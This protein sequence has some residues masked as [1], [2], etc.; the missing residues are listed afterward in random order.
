[1]TNN[2]EVTTN[3]HKSSIAQGSMIPLPALYQPQSFTPSLEEQKDDW[4]PS[5]ILGFLKRRALVIAGVA[6]LVMAGV[7][8]KT[9]TEKPIYQSDFLMLVEPLKDE[10]QWKNITSP[11][12]DDNLPKS[13]LD[14]ES[15]I[16][17]LK[18]RELLDKA[19]NNLKPIYPNISFN[20]LA[21]N[22][23][24]NR[25]RKTKALN[26][27]YSSPDAKKVK[28][29]LDA[30]AQSY[31][32]Y[33]LQERQTELRQGLQFVEEKLPPLRNRVDKLENQIKTFRQKYNFYNPESELGLITGQLSS[34]I[35]KRQSIDTELATLR[36]NLASLQANPG[37]LAVLN[38]AKLYQNLLSQVRQLEA[39]IAQESARF[40][41][42]NPR[43]QTFLDRRQRLL[44]LL[45]QE[46][47]RILGVQLAGVVT[48]IQLLEVRSQELAKIERQ[49]QSR[50]QQLPVLEKRFIGLQRNLKF[51]TESLN[52]F[53]ATRETLQIAIAQTELPWKLIQ[54]ANQPLLPMSP[55]ITRNLL[56]GLVASTI[57][58][59]GAGVIF[60]RM[61]DTYHSVDEL[62]ERVKFPLLGTIPVEKELATME[63]GNKKAKDI[64]RKRSKKEVQDV[65]TND[66]SIL[67][68]ME[69]PESAIPQPKTN[70]ESSQFW[71]AFQVLLNNIRLLGSD[72]PI[73]SIVISSSMP[74]EGKS[75]VSYYLSQ[76][77][78]SVGL[79]VLLVDTDMRNPSIH[80]MADLTNLWG[81]SSL[82]SGDFSVEQAIQKIPNSQCSVITAGMRP[83]DTIKLLS[84]E[85]MKRIMMQ[86]QVEYD[87]V[88]YDAPPLT[89]LADASIVATHTD[90]IIAVARIDKTNKTTFSKALDGLKISPINV[91]GIIANGD[92]H[93]FKGY[94]KYYYY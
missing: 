5:Q 58:G 38:N 32:N 28:V 10:D 59:V 1:V 49:L 83:P 40:R 84:S 69:L 81:L 93:K 31:L 63:Q 90:G 53:L 44:P 12:G 35:E 79:K 61:D 4:S 71:E 17:V 55:N 56:M 23:N 2:S 82:I 3:S 14:Y 94:D 73:R 50:S 51:A 7:A 60:E 24:I 46:A 19:I 29:V 57:L 77:A 47:E 30:I 70:I 27:S 67:P 42:A 33:S 66:N 76:I 16:L 68:E 43:M 87:L 8:A 62:K 9:F 72:N 89:G 11:L 75:T 45:Q 22:L 39:E 36:A 80:K 91:L 54:Q 26:V 65:L 92:K 34:S 78:A 74:G 85:K 48:Q 20:S 15:Q 6:T 21:S 18:S 41:D 52:R 86:F 88:V 25:Y 13:G 64:K 37:Q